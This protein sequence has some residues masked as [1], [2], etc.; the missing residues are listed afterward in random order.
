MVALA[1]PG[2]DLPFILAATS[3]ALAAGWGAALLTIVTGRLV[4]AAPALALVAAGALGAAASLPGLS[5]SAMPL[6]LAALPTEAWWVARNRRAAGLAGA[7]ALAAFVAILAGTGATA[8]A[9]M[10]PWIAPA[11]WIAAVW[12][13]RDAFLGRNVVAVGFSAWENV[14]DGALLRFDPAGAV[15]EASI[16]ATPLLGLDPAL[17]AGSGFFGRLHVADR[18]DYLAALSDLRAGAPGMSLSLRLRA[19]AAAPGDGSGY[20]DLTLD[21]ASCANGEFVA[22][23]LRKK[24][25]VFASANPADDSDRLEV[26][27]SRFLAAVSHELRTPLNAIIGFSDMMLH[28]LFGPFADERQREYVGLISES[29][30]HLLGVVNS[31]LDMS[32]IE[33]GT[34][35]INTEPFV[36]GETVDMSTLMLARQAA[37]KNIEI[38]KAIDETAEMTGDRRAVQQILIN[39]LSNAVKFTPDG[40]R[41]AVSAN[42]RPGI[43]EFSVSDNGI[44]IAEADLSRIGRPFTQIEN[45]LTRSYDGAGLG[46]S[47]VK[48]LVELHK[49]SMAIESAP[50]QGTTVR[51]GLPDCGEKD[52]Q[53]RRHE[54]HRKFG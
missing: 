31:I 37:A 7:L 18:V 20:L 45:D 53:E 17:L 30:S 40:G 21:L 35:A 49:G 15:T 26:A 28:G 4:L 34:Y 54:A 51:I 6:L 24:Q 11:I 38:V 12:M 33:A 36:F 10:T 29:G 52:R 5:G 47:L 23:W 22:G 19:P 39:L 1:L 48:G 41:V 16:G 25:S 32:K 13:R 42:R 43:F 46:L 44:G 50:G 2:S 3:V 27:K 9:S 8:P 14:V